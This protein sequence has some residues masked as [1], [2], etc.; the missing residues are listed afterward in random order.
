MKHLAKWVAFSCQNIYRY[1]MKTNF[2]AFQGLNYNCM[3][4]WNIKHYIK[5][6]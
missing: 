2:C 6:C 3:A 4:E 1:K 5:H